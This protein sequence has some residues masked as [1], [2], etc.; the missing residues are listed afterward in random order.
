[1]G[2]RMMLA[3]AVFAE[4]RVKYRRHKLP[5][6]PG[7]SRRRRSAVV[8]LPTLF[9]L[10]NCVCG[11]AS[12]HYAARGNTPVTGLAS[13]YALAGYLIFTG[14]FFDMFDGF[15]ARLT[16]AT[17]EFGAELDSLA[18]MVTFG[19]APAFLTLQFVAGRISGGAEMPRIYVD[20]WGPNA[21][22]NMGKLFW[23][24][25][26]LYVICAAL[27]LAR[28][29][30]LSNDDHMAFRGMPSPG[31]AGVVASSIIFFETI[32]G[33]WHL[34]R[35]NMPEPVRGGFQDAFPY[36]LPFLLL[37][38]ALLMVSRFA[39][40]HLINR[41]LRGRRRFNYLVGIVLI[42]MVLFWQP[43]ITVLCGIYIYALS[44][45]VAWLM[46]VILRRPAPRP[47][48]AAGRAP[49][50]QDKPTETRP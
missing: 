47:A 25:G 27:R 18:D 6:G 32:T 34:I 21:D 2:Y 33:S 12:M 9:T 44:A 31:A 37:I 43:Q 22:S 38:S 41:F 23:T 16:R 15:L 39:Y 36:I 49:A 13:N 4:E 14:M 17:S 50:A 46:R 19:V 5:L 45:P 10:A 40:A 42:L 35:F 3:G 26:A 28:F 8:V 1:M 7:R 30:V 48:L 20:A 11:F 24:I 29:N